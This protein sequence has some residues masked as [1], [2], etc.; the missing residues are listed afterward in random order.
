MDRIW[1][2]RLIEN[3]LRVGVMGVKIDHIGGQTSVLETQYHEDAGRWC[4]EQKLALIDGDPGKT[5][6]M[7]AERRYLTEYRDSKKL[8]PGMIDAGYIVTNAEG[9]QTQI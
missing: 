8:V 2:L 4:K 5:L 6:Y 7:E 3:G 1:P 9:K